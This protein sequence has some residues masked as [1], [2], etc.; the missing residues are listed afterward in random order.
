M[1]NEEQERL[2]LLAELMG[3]SLEEAADLIGD[4]TVTDVLRMR[5]Q[6]QQAAE[7]TAPDYDTVLLAFLDAL[8]TN[9]ANFLEAM[10]VSTAATHDA[11]ARLETVISK[12]RAPA[13]KAPQDVLDEGEFLKQQLAGVVS[14]ETPGPKF[15]KGQTETKPIPPGLDVLAV[16][17]RPR[18]TKKIP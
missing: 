2:Q 7:R 1:N 9:T 3:M 4:M 10:N 15:K 17:V 5:L 13:R 8:N 11:L 12:N 18:A 16:A 14:P 6:Q